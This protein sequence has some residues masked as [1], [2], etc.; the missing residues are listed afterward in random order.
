MKDFS[1]KVAFITGGSAGIGLALAEALGRQGMQ[2]MIAGK[3]RGNLD[4]ALE[5]LK[6]KGITAEAVTC[7]VA[8]RK[9]VQA[10]ALATI[11]KFGKVHLV[12][13]NAGVAIGGGI[14]E[15][16]EADWRW[17]IDVN[18]M[19]VVHG[20]EIFAPLIAQHGEGGHIVNVSSM[21]G[22][23]AGNVGEPYAATKYAV[24]GMSEGWRNQLAP[25][26][27]GVS[28]LCPGFVRTK[29]GDSRRN[30]P[31]GG[32]GMHADPE[33]DQALRQAI[34]EGM[35]PATA[36]A[37]TIECI[38]ADE[39]YIITHPER[40][41]VVEARGKALLEAFDSAAKSPALAGYVPQD[42]SVLRGGTK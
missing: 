33:R 32:S 29:I 23:F 27:I 41:D 37:R 9:D 19:G 38:K 30:A 28:V 25:K 20:T 13:N 42:L 5:E 22:L 7:D 16:T 21:A 2:V 1:G 35:D 40:R 10:A 11:A 8:S 26:G 12:I 34:A 3:N 31:G 15:V 18:I 6:A 39:L 4:S 36:A 14:G 17:I 24:V